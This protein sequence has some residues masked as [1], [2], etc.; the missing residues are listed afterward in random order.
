MR[1]LKLYEDLNT[2]TDWTKD[3]FDL[4]TEVLVGI[5]RTEWETEIL[6]LLLT[7]LNT[8][9][10]ARIEEVDE[11]E[12][13]DDLASDY[14]YRLSLDG[15]IPARKILSLFPNPTKESLAEGYDRINIYVMA[16]SNSSALRLGL[17]NDQ[18]LFK[19]S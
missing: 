9:T 2:L 1:H 3:L 17:S 16:P 19:F 7:A 18:G 4:H 15:D 5:H 8:I 14:Q 10:Y 11:E 12:L 13:D 6:Q